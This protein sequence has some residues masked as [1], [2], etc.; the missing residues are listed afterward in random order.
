MSSCFVLI[1]DEGTGSKLSTLSN[2]ILM[3]KNKEV[4][5]FFWRLERLL[6]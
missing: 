2:K 4:A 6:L 5:I 3:R 1:E